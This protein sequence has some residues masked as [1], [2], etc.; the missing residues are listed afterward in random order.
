MLITLNSTFK[1]ISLIHAEAYKYRIN[2]LIQR[3]IETFEEK[4]FDN[5]KYNIGGQI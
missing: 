2:K 4:Y 3:K 5:F 1:Y